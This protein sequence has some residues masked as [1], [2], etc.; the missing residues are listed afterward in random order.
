MK[1]AYLIEPPFNYRT[2][3]G[4]VTG[5]DVK[6]ARFI[7]SELQLG[8]F[9]T[10]ETEFAELL[11]R[12]AV[13]DWDMT[14][15]LFGTEERKQIASFSR[16]IWAL[17]DG[18]LVKAGNP[19]NLTGYVSLANTETARLAVIRD[20]FQHRSAIE[21]NVPDH[22]IEIFETYTVAAQ[23]VADGTVDAYASVGRAHSGFIERNNEM[24]LEL[25]LV[26]GSEK[27]PAFGSFGFA[28]GNINLR[29]KVDEVLS[30]YLGSSEHRV[31]MATFGFSDAEVDTVAYWQG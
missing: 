28:I 25:I 23:A 8:E 22:R 7:N 26:P 13:G 29:T 16:P 1:F 14:T 21:F 20:Q 9:E 10:I 24:E 3:D 15:G 27:K 30:R 2:E 18:L 6:L 17:P 31:M 4:A 12:V 11:P 5:C 19:K